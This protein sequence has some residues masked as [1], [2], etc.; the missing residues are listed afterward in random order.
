MST[1]NHHPSIGTPSAS[2]SR[3]FPNTDNQ[4]RK[5]KHSIV[6]LCTCLHQNCSHRTMGPVAYHGPMGEWGVMEK[7][8][9]P[10]EYPPPYIYRLC[11]HCEDWQW[12]QHL[13]CPC[14]SSVECY[15]G[16]DYTHHSTYMREAEDVELPLQTL[17][18]VPESSGTSFAVTEN[19]VMYGESSRSGSQSHIPGRTAGRL[20]RYF[21]K[22][23]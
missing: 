17:E 9:S 23:R 14:P 18:H 5:I 13:N 15:D 8:L 19:G 16:Q 3:R 2:E 22:K 11:E 7:S 6:L 21:L 1:Q 10:W 20:R 4:T 12:Q